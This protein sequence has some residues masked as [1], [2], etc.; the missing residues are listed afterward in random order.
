MASMSLIRFSCSLSSVHVL[1]STMWAD[2]A[3]DVMASF[4]AA[5]NTSDAK[6][7]SKIPF[8]A[9]HLSAPFSYSTEPQLGSRS[10]ERF[11]DMF[12]FKAAFLQL[13][14]NQNSEQT[15][16]S[17]NCDNQYNILHQPIQYTEST[18]DQTAAS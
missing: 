3:G 2:F 15:T 17:L 6:A 16:L 9:G 5:T 14:Q 18:Y 10:S 4:Q 1:T 8:S 13:H 7:K 12:N 11:A